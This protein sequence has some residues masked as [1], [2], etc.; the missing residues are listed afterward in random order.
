[1]VL[2]FWG[3]KPTIGLLLSLCDGWWFQRYPRLWWEGSTVE[4]LW[5]LTNV[6]PQ[7]SAS[8]MASEASPVGAGSSSL[9]ELWRLLSAQH[10]TG[11]Y[12][13]IPRPRAFSSHG[14]E[15]WLY[16]GLQKM[17]AP[18]TVTSTCTTRLREAPS[19]ACSQSGSSTWA[20][21]S[22]VSSSGSSA[23]Y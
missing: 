21:S 11:P 9:R 6:W 23:T 1:M 17:L 12:P 18:V 2:P 14:K 7:A 13:T 22:Y 20:W 5:R 19:L 4:W 16:A 8:W 10:S 15:R 3:S